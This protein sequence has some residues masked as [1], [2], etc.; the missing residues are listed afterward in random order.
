MIRSSTVDDVVRRSARRHPDRTALHF[1]DRT[2]SYS[3]LD[4]AV[5][6]AAGALLDLGLHKGDRVAAYGRNSD[7]YLLGFLGCA[8]A[9]LVHVPVNYALTGDELSY[10][11]E[12][13]GSRAALVD[14]ALAPELAKVGGGL[15]V[16]LPLRDA[17]D[18]L[19]DR[20]RDGDLPELDVEVADTDLV[21]LLY[22][23][24]TTSRPKG[25]M[26]THR[27]LVHEYL[28]CIVSLDL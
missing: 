23:S 10:L 11:I 24:G 16:V 4:D 26:M 3:E 1:A 22:T 5:T 2:W 14:P 15:D 27:A 18:C 13:S 12:Q 17:A 6:R 8:R 7:A 20:I 28:S 25:A 19:L 9:G 21:Q